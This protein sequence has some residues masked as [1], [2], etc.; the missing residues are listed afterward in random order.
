MDDPAVKKRFE[1]ALIGLQVETKG[2][3]TNHNENLT[4]QGAIEVWNALKLADLK[5]VPAA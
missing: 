5:V 2:I 4:A 3:V 1:D